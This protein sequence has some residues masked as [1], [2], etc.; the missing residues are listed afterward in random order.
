M[1]D[2]SGVDLPSLLAVVCA[3]VLAGGICLW[4]KRD[5]EREADTFRA[6]GVR[7]IGTVVG[8]EVR[9]VVTD[10]ES[11]WRHDRWSP[12]VEFTDREGNAVTFV[13]TLLTHPTDAVPVNSRVAVVYPPEDPKKAEMADAL[14]N[15]SAGRLDRSGQFVSSSGGYRGLFFG[16][17][18]FLSVLCVILVSLVL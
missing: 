14:G 3:A 18:V 1:S 2:S 5:D 13:S 6:R 9:S 11:N 12:V 7:T 10:A 15:P 16:L 8:H 4:M 17:F